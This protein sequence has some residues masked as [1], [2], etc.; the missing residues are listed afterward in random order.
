MLDPHLVYGGESSGKRNVVHHKGAEDIM[1]HVKL[2]RKEESK[3]IL[4][5]KI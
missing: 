2:Y 3:R 1:E 4:L 5:I